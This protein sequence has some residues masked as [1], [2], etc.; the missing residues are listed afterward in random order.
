VHPDGTNA[1]LDVTLRRP[2][3]PPDRGDQRER[4]EE[5]EPGKDQD[6]GPAPPVHDLGRACVRGSRPRR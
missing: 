1:S 6:L 4:A 5:D 2:G 3:P